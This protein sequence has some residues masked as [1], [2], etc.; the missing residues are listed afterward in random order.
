MRLPTELKTLAAATAQ[1]KV[2]RPIEVEQQ[3]QQKAKGRKLVV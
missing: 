1:E 3:Q 2:F